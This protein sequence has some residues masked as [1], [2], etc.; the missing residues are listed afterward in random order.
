MNK[1]NRRYETIAW[2]ALFLWVGARDLLP[3]LPIGTGM[4]GIGLIL[5]GINL[6]R[7]LSDLPIN[8][9]STALGIT[10]CLVGAVELFR[11]LQGMQV[12]LPFFPV[13]L[14]MIG[15]GFLAHSLTG[16][17]TAKTAKTANGQPE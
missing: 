6:A 13:L 15:V 16:M 17:K 1:L 4:L 8:G 9:V 2:G 14:V 10:A 3:G 7:R 5:L 11:S 12:E